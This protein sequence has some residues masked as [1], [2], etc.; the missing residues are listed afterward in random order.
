MKAEELALLAGAAAL[1]VGGG[2]AAGLAV[3]SRAEFAGALE[4]A[5]ALTV[6]NLSKP[7]RD[8][9]VAHGAFES[10]F[11]TARAAKAGF[12]VFN[13][14]AGSAWD[15]ERWTDVGGD[16]EY[17]AQ[18]NVRRIDQVW[19]KYASL[20]AAVADYWSFLGPSQNRGRYV[21]ARA[22]LSA[23]DVSGFCRELYAAGYF[24]LPAATYT[25]RMNGVL[26]EVRGY[27]K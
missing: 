14:T 5:S 3:M 12:N 26:L 13:L 27:L 22:R 1:G 6:P 16:T 23:G 21:A 15:G 8:L 20:D 25:A 2:A 7:A 18:G 11:G 17:D 24:T 19:R 10:G 4:M 9:L